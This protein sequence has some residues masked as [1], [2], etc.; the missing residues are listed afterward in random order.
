[1]RTIKIPSKSNPSIFREVRI[2]EG[3]V[4]ETI[5]EC[6]C[7]A[8]VWNRISNGRSGKAECSHILQ[9]KEIL[10]KETRVDKNNENI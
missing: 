8:N 1:M 4:G 10:R 2:K 7:P 5:F 3:L 6:S 9:A